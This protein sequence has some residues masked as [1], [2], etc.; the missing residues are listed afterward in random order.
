[1]LREIDVM[2]VSDLVVYNILFVELE[3][4]LSEFNPSDP[5]VTNRIKVGKQHTVI[6]HVDDYMSSHV[7]PNVNDK[8]KEWINH[9]YDK[10]G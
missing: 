6:L 5:C 2:L 3:K 10:H 7:N 4:I 9:N 1:M 8:L